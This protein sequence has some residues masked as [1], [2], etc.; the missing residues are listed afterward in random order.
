V[1]DQQGAAQAELF[2]P[3]PYQL[4]ILRPY[5]PNGQDV[6]VDLD[7]PGEAEGER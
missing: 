7:A 2:T 5:V 4:P 1:S 6:C 3:P